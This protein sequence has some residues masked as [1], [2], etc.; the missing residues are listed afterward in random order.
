[1]GIREGYGVSGRRSE[2]SKGSMTWMGKF[3]TIHKG[4]LLRGV[5]D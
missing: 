5:L 2:R 1:M 3:Y 4:G